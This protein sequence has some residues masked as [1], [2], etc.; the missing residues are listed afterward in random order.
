M[1]N[2]SITIDGETIEVEEGKTILEAA[3]EQGIDIPTLCHDPRLKP[4]AACRLCLV[5]VE[6]ARGPV[7]ACNTKVTPGMVIKTKSEAIFESRQIALELLLS[8]HYGDC[9]SPCSLACPAGIDIQGQIAHIANG[10]YLE[11]LK[12]IK[13][14]NPLPLVCGRV[15]PRFCEKQCRRQLVDEPVAINMLKRFVADMDARTGGPYVPPVKPATGHRVAIIGGGPAG[16]SAAY[17]LA[18]EGHMVSI[19][20][21]NPELGGMLRYG[22]PEYRLPKSVLDKEIA[23]ITRLCREVK[24]NTRLGRDI[25]IESLKKQGFEAIFLALGAQTD[26][27]MCI[28]GEELPG[29]YSGIGFLRDVIMGKKLEPGRRVAVV[30]GGNTAIDAAR[31]VL[32]LGAEEV[33]VIYRR[34]RSEMPANDEEI[35]GA[36]QEGIEFQFL[37]NPVRITSKNGKVESVECLRMQ[38]G[39]PDASGRRRPE[40]VPGSEFIVPVNTVI[41]AL[42]QSV[43][44]SSLR[45]NPEISLNTKGGIAIT[46]ETMMTGMPGVFSGGDCTTGPATAVEAIGAG[47]R[48]AIY[49]D[50]YLK[51]Q[52]VI[53][54]EKPYNCS[55]GDLKSIDKAELADVEPVKRTLMPALE[56]EERR[57]SFAEIETGISEDAARE[58]AGRCLSCG[59]QAVFD[60]KLRELATEYQVNDREYEGKKRRLLIHE[61][62]HPYILR[63]PN[64]C[65]LCGKCVRICNEVEGVNALGYVHRGISTTVEPSLGLPLAETSCDSCGQC[66]STCPT[67]AIVHKTGL[68]KPGPFKLKTVSTVCPHC[69]IGC[70]LELKVC[71][72]EIIKVTSA[73]GSPVNN[74]NLCRRGAFEISNKK[75]EK[76]LLRPLINL[77]GRMIES[78]WEEALSLAARGLQQIINISGPESIAVLS[79]PIWTNEENYLVQKMARAALG[80]NN[81]GCLSAFAMN[82]SPARVTGIPASSCS[83]NDILQSDFIMVYDCDLA[84]DYPISGIKVRE[85]VSRGSRLTILSNHQTVLDAIARVS[86]KVNRRTSAGLLQAMLHYILSYDMVD[87]EFIRSRTSG[88]QRL[89]DKIKKLD[90]DIITSIPWVKP[91]RIIE[92]IHMYVRAKRPVIIVNADTITPAE[93]DLLNDLALITGNIGRSGAGI[94]ML[95]TPGNSQGLLDMGVS[96]AYLPGQENYTRTARKRYASQWGVKIPGKKGKNSLGILTGIERG[97]I[98][99]LLVCGREALGKIGNGIFGVPLFSVLIDT[100]A[101]EGRPYPQVVLP[102]AAFSESEG[103]Y[104]NCERRIQP[105]HQ[106]VKPPAGRQNWEIITALSSAAGYS[107][108]YISIQDIQQ[109]LADALPFYR[110]VADG[111]NSDLGESAMIGEQDHFKIPVLK[112]SDSHDIMRVL[113]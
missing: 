24:C 50:Q 53:P 6:K 100:R 102:G 12:L 77:D 2:I 112:V 103:T 90:A 95:R 113:R 74:G 89:A 48:A 27:K 70:N 16:L 33:T 59:C 54:L 44:V 11:A 42:G 108:K 73:S 18:L 76:R 56:P 30:G 19:F 37:S 55:K 15:C 14:S 68:P 75:A 31:T 13:E 21:A 93:L 7:P 35:E 57:H 22:I 82:E 69:S 62:E 1:P 107:M 32:R 34:S 36:T 67:G 91:S 63:D 28:P 106:A 5:E 52:K 51:G 99:G 20:E 101:P 65:I 87:H 60:C 92:V 43:D 79:S 8:D 40:P 98:Q 88:F 45:Q 85:A 49:I 111:K 39:A 4:T 72:D 17:Y 86:L 47:H 9:V 66:V 81:L 46:G 84:R 80:T 71:G 97:E 29:V 26:Q 38:L 41:M 105:L 104:T 3:Q 109:E 96:P 78:D 61:Q 25:S 94:L 110:A 23:S 83:L 64:K 10:H 58:E